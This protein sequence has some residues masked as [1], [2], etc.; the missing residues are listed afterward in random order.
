MNAGMGF[1]VLDAVACDDARRVQGA[2]QVAG[3]LEQAVLNEQ[4]GATR[5]KWARQRQRGRKTGVYL[6]PVILNEVGGCVGSV[7]C[8]LFDEVSK[9]IDKVVEFGEG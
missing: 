6:R 1:V 5:C 4:Q 7:E 8:C 2:E 9:Q 3:G